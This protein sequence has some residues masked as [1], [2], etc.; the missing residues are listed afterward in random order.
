MVVCINQYTPFPKNE[1]LTP[2]PGRDHA[3]VLNFPKLTSYC[4][5]THTCFWIDLA[6]QQKLS[7]KNQQNYGVQ[8]ASSYSK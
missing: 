2:I 1:R 6:N 5:T 3:F 8:E 4:H 7:G